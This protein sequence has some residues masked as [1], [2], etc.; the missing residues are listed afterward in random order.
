[1]IWFLKN[2][3]ISLKNQLLVS[4]AIITAVSAGITLGICYGILYS[5]R[6]TVTESATTNIID[7][8]NSNEL[9]LATEI[10]N[11]INQQLIIIGE[12]V[13]M[14]SS[15]YSSVLM[16]YATYGS[17]GS[18]LLKHEPSF[19]EY[20]FLEDCSSSD[21]PSDYG[22]LSKRSRLP[23]FVNGSLLH[24]SVYLYSSAYQHAAR[25]NQ[26]WTE[27]T[28]KDTS[29]NHVIDGL[30]YQDR[31]MSLMYTKGPSTTVM[32]YLSTK[33]GSGNDYTS[34]H[35]TFPGMVKNVTNYD[36]PNREWFKLAPIDS[37]HLYGPYVETFTRQPVV[38]LSSMKKSSVIGS[39]DS[40]PL[41][42]VS[43]AVMLIS[44]LVAIVNSVQYTDGGFGVLVALPSK[45]VLVWKDSSTAT[46]FPETNSFKT[47]AD[48]DSK[49]AQHDVSTKSVFE[50]IDAGGVT[51]IVSVV[52][53]FPSSQSGT[54]TLSNTLSIL[55]FAQRSLAESSL[56][57]LKSNIR[58]TT[59][60]I[61]TVTIIIILCTV[62][63]TMLLVYGVIYFITG[64]LETMRRISQEIMDISAEDED[65]K[66]YQSV[67][68]KAY[69]NLSR[70]DEVGILASDYYNIVCLLHN[71]NLAKKEAPKYPPNPF[72]VGL[73]H[74]NITWS[75]YVRHFDAYNETQLPEVVANEVNLQ[76]YND[77]TADLDV[78]GSLNNNAKV[79]PMLP[80]SKGNEFAA[81]PTAEPHVAPRR[82]S[83][84][85]QPLRSEGYYT[86][87]AEVIQVSYFSSLKSQLWGL[88]A[89]LL[90]GIIVTMLVTV[91]SLS[92][93]GATW[94][95][96]STTVIN[97][98]QIANMEAI[99]FAKSLYVKSYYQQLTMD[100]NTAAVFMTDLVN[101]NL[102]RSSWLEEKDYLPSYTINL[103]DKPE[104]THL[105]PP[106]TDFSVYYSPDYAFCPCDNLYNS[107]E[108]RLTSLSD[109]KFRSFFHTYNF[110]SFMQ[111]GVE[112]HGFT[113]YLPYLST[114]TSSN[115]PSQPTSCQINLP[116][117]DYCT[118][119]YQSTRCGTGSGT[120]PSYDPRC[121]QWYYQGKNEAKYDQVSFLVPRTS[122]SGAFVQTAY[123]PI[124]KNNAFYGVMSTNYL[125]SR[126]SN[127]INS[128]RIL[129]TGYCYLVD[130]T[131]SAVVSHPK[132]SGTCSTLQCVEGMSDSEFGAF[133]IYKYIQSASSSGE[134]YKK[135][136]A[137]WRIT[138]SRVTY[139]SVDYAIIAT[140]PNSEVERVSTDTNK[141]INKSVVAMII[142]FAFCIAIFLFILVFFSYWMIIQ[143]VNP[144]NDLREVFAL[145]RNDDLTGTIPTKASSKDMKL[146]LDAFSKLMVAL[147]FGSESYSKGDNNRAQSAFQDALDLFT[148]TG[149]KK[150]IGASQNNL[151][152]V[153]LSF[154]KHTE[155]ENYCI[156]A[157]QNAEELLSELS[158]DSQ[159]ANQNVDV[160]KAKRVLSDRKGNLAIIYLQQ[161]RFAD[162]FAI[163]E[164]LLAEDKKIGY[165][166][167]L[168][169]K[170]GTLGQYYLKQGE[171]KSA[172]KVFKSALDFIRRKDESMFS[173]EWNQDEAESAEQIALH[174][175]ATLEEVKK[176]PHFE[177]AYIE[178]LSKSTTMHTATVLKILLLLQKVMKNDPQR[179][180]DLRSLERIAEYCDFDLSGTVGKQSGNS[181][182]VGGPKRVAF[183]IDYSGSM[184]GA[185][186]RSAIENVLNIFNTHIFAGD[187]IM[188]V[189]FNADVRIELPLTTKQGNEERI[190]SQISALVRPNGGTAFY[191]AIQSTLQQMK[192]QGNSKSDWIIAFTD[193]EDNCSRSCSVS[194]AS[195]S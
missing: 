99:T 34:V 74:F 94:M 193:G 179:K 195:Y 88:S 90:I 36:A 101:D 43:A 50:Y 92:R 122:S 152:V 123:I 156:S 1:M 192:Q 171:V 52:P 136:G 27:L 138:A 131:T 22:P 134:I 161:E 86:V 10:A 46:I 114:P 66:D 169:V 113:R 26:S 139:G 177:S 98:K 144:V 186:I 119:L 25:N 15:L 143:I 176:S 164:S 145:V 18:T 170:Q 38:T 172:E 14:V 63:G 87:N 68:Q 75:Q 30:S 182:S 79:I 137:D 153:M 116:A 91:V 35:R 105:S 194:T 175:I 111:L 163:I 132:L 149:N 107:N 76:T 78:L 160:M 55:V 12:S 85:S 108:T 165:I 117:S 159:N 104:R 190:A 148:L 62:V 39:D 40:K 118:N 45:K 21:C 151:S 127:V 60:Q 178:A 180:D 110:I 59:V 106:T 184:S 53:F 167:G 102:T 73:P 130:A 16:P 155:A 11:S 51:W 71:K 7:Q 47:L 185:K 128:L 135:Q 64:P 41:T 23:S 9:A 6:D 77:E 89:I 100:L 121:R 65:R 140:V 24:S 126:L 37:Y 33:I 142:A 96:T 168:V 97:A 3:K 67:L 120:Y 166:R 181:T 72:H 57:S 141:S 84:Q 188:I 150:G 154:N 49:L 83:R 31:D 109:I 95:S 187:S 173:S 2:D 48:F 191:A 44:D 42:I 93:Q 82:R 157:I 80:L 124:Q 69:I 146:L 133:N 54:S 129:D 58:T 125:A 19:R 56:D 158:S 112:E 32:F 5:L 8:T 28:S 61:T 103:F 13:C 81:L 17:S 174:N 4:Y 183:V 189:T 147:R 29:I 115:N 20:N 70:T 162:A